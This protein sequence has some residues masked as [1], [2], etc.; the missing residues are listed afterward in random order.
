MSCQVYINVSRC[1]VKR[2]WKWSLKLYYRAPLNIL[3]DSRT[4]TAP[5]KKTC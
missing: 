3:I 5:L 1:K 4:S 2:Q